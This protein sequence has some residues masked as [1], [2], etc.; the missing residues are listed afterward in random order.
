MLSRDGSG[1]RAAYAE[2]A[3]RVTKPRSLIPRCVYCGAPRPT[4]EHVDTCRG[5]RERMDK[6]GNCGFQ[7][8]FRKPPNEADYCR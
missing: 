5:D 7:R 3:T 6:V 1:T 2:G 4:P 8:K